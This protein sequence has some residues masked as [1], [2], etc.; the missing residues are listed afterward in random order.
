MEVKYAFSTNDKVEK[1]LNYKETV[2]LEKGIDITIEWA[3]KQGHQKFKY[4]KNLELVSI[5]TPKTWS[6]KLL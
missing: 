2:S 3:K 5:S 1:L 6:E 4:L